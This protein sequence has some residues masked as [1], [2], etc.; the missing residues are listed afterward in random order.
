[1]SVVE[2]LHYPVLCLSRDTSISV[3]PDPGALC[4]CNAKALWGNRYFEG[5]LVFDSSAR[6][7]RVTDASPAVPVSAVRQ[8]LM[9]LLNQSVPVRLSMEEIGPPSLEQVKERVLESID[10][11]P[12]FWEAGGELAELKSRIARASGV[13]QLAA[14]LG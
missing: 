14:I 1:M 7:Y 5:L 4:R 3:R 9:R 10:G 6:R 12:E 13:P 11:D 8:G 2:T